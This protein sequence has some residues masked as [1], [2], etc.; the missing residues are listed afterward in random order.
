MKS[1]ARKSIRTAAIAA[2]ASAALLASGPV[3]AADAFVLPTDPLA[4]GLDGWARPLTLDEASSTRTTY[5]EWDIFDQP[6]GKDPFSPGDPLEN[7]PDISNRNPNSTPSNP[8]I[9]YNTIDGAFLAN[10]E[11]IYNQAG[12]IH[13]QTD[14][15]LDNLGEFY[16]TRFLLQLRTL[17]TQ[18]DVNNI[19]LDLTNDGI[20]NGT[21]I[22]E[23]G[24]Y[25]HEE[26]Y[27]VNAPFSVPGVGTFDSWTERHLWTFEIPGSPLFAQIDF[28][29]WADSTSLDRVAID[30]FAT[31][32]PEPASLGLVM[33]GG[34]GFVRRRKRK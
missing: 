4:W 14:L 23:L 8:V 30:T 20:N 25:K 24:N 18:L 29:V 5:Q 27:A 12:P 32:V 9:T 19:R 3:M 15:P 11:N 33:L 28:G 6:N 22:S 16:T 10:G 1:I 7:N 2:A 31:V 34:L 17:G 26:L 13:P 21:L